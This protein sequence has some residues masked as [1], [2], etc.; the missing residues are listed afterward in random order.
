MRSLILLAT[1]AVLI[2]SVVAQ[3][4]TPKKFALPDEE[5]QKK[6][7]TI[8][9]EAYK[10]DYEIAKTSI[11]KVELAKKLMKEGLA[12]NDD[13]V[14]RFVLF[15]MS[16]DLAAGQGNL[17]VSMD[18]VQQI[19]DSYD[20]DKSAMQL[21]TARSVAKVLKTS[22]EHQDFVSLLKPLIDEMISQ[23][24]YESA[25]ALASIALT[26]SK[27]GRNSSQVNW[28]ISRLQE[29]SEIEKHFLLAK[30]A[31]ETLEKEPVD[32]RANYIA[33]RF[34]CFDKGEW[35]R[36]IPMLALGND[37]ALKKLAILELNEPARELQVGDEWWAYAETLSNLREQ[38][39]VYLHV[40]VK[41]E[42][43]IDSLTGLQ[44]ARVSKRL[45]DIASIEK[46]SVLW[47]SRAVKEV[48]LEGRGRTEKNSRPIEVAIT[49]SIGLSLKLIPEG[50][51]WMGTNEVVRELNAAGIIL[52]EG[53]GVDDEQPRHRVKITRS[54]Y[55]GQYEVTKEQFAKFVKATLYETDAEKDE[56]G[57]WGYD[58]KLQDFKRSR[59][60]SWRNTGWPQ[61]DQDPVTFVTWNDA[62]AFCRWLGEKEGRKYRLPTEAEWEYCCRAGSDKRFVAGDI[63]DSL[64]GY[65]NVRDVS[66]QKKFVYEDYNKYPCCRFEDGWVFTAPVGRFQP[67]PFGLHDMNGNVAEWCED[68]FDERAYKSR[69]GVTLDP[70]VA[71]G[72]ANRVL[73][74]GSWF[75]NPSSTRSSDRYSLP[76]ATRD[77]NDGFRVVLVVS[78]KVSPAA[79]NGK[80]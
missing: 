69:K 20:V 52:P 37:E 70:L 71:A 8:I 79:K 12:T 55:M 47:I 39:S 29:I 57:S 35:A 64:Q 21:V 77:G 66:Y 65:G 41:Y 14:G 7:T 51:F 33:G 3:D 80:R 76:P 19:A 59:E 34:Y 45:A 2:S 56:K 54:F 25:K 42:Q 49:N 23:D 5:S 10:A 73:R 78:E 26:S 60:F 36:G 32:S 58:I 46:K 16:R 53:D 43:A 6:A 74:G 40:A 27:E 44:H 11:Q 31:L 61:T 48:S 72:S 38:E 68:V 1:F 28:L 63:Q 18:A 15:R 62:K 24:Q 4:G 50:E 17:P 75:F 67:N 13:P 9:L 30:V 22:R